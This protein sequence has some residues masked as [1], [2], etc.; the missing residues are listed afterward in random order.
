MLHPPWR[1]AFPCWARGGGLDT[2]R[3]AY[4]GRQASGAVAQMTPFRPALQ[5]GQEKLSRRQAGFTRR[6]QEGLGV[7]RRPLHQPGLAV[8]TT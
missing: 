2:G 6:G 5:L 8:G 7:E 1:H 3:K 4:F